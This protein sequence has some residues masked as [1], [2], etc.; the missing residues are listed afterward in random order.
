MFLIWTCSC[1]VKIFFMEPNDDKYPNSWDIMAYCLNY[2]S[3]RKYIW[4]V[5]V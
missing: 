1:H 2:L 3:G 4:I 5:P